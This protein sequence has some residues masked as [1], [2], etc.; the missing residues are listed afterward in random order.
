MK[1][2][3][4]ILIMVIGLLSSAH[5]FA[6]SDNT[7]PIVTSIKVINNPVT[8]PGIVKVEM[9]IIED[10]AGV[11]MISG[12]LMHVNSLG[13][14]GDFQH[15][16]NQCEGFCIDCSSKPLFTG[17]H[18]LNIPVSEKFKEGQW[19][20]EFRISDFAGNDKYYFS[21]YNNGKLYNGK[22]FFFPSDLE[23]GVNYEYYVAGSSDVIYDPLEIVDEFPN[24]DEFSVTNPNLV[25]RI[26]KLNEG[27]AARI[28]MKGSNI[29]SKEAFNT[30][31]GKNKTI[32]AICDEYRWI[33]NGLDIV[34]PKDI[35]V[36][37]IISTLSGRDYNNDKTIVKIDFANNGVLPGKAQFRMKSDYL[38]SLNNI[39]GTLKLY[40]ISNDGNIVKEEANPNFDLVF[41]GT[42]K[43]CY[44]DITHNSSFAISSGVLKNKALSIKGAK[45][46]LSNTSFIYNG[47]V[48]M[49]TIKKIGG[50]ALKKGVDYTVKWSNKS[51]KNVGTYTVTVT[52]KNA[53]A[54]TAKATFKI[55]PKGTSIKRFVN[56]KRAITIK[57]G[58]Q[59][60]K[61]STSHI[62]GYQIQLATNSKF[63]KNKKNVTVKGFKKV[64]KKVGKLNGGTKY[65]V[66]IRT[67]KTIKGKKYYS[68]WSKVKAIKTKK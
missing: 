43:W 40:H 61:M 27:Q 4:P 51:P 48:C 57:W 28:L 67:Y 63:T 46:V 64:S 58:K 52:G 36:K 32:V 59:T 17:T 34:Q 1:K 38:Y 19:V 14:W 13:E 6:E 20:F 30:I 56:G 54:G 47:K 15:T 45:I 35:D 3:I 55:N 5:V 65:Y 21:E 62:T 18:I 23:Y 9:E 25:N 7:A 66:K 11:C 22:F 60:A 68:K 49:P 44:F 42:D 12:Q 50:K 39:K 33:F 10:S 41:D 37:A 24:A 8:R 2:L 29:L 31:K 53:Y 16:N 26:E